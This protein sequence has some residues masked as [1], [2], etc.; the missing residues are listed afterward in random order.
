M[1]AGWPLVMNMYYRY[2]VFWAVISLLP[3]C[4]LFSAEVSLGPLLSYMKFVGCLS[5][6]KR[7]PAV[8]YDLTFI[9]WQWKAA[10]ID[11]FIFPM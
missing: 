2:H 4:P 6:F 7:I 8:S 5:L 1:M 10:H 11:M 9:F 3:A